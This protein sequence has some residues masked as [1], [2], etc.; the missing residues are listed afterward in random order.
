MNVFISNPLDTDGYKQLR[1]LTLPPGGR[2][3][4]EDSEVWDQPAAAGGLVLTP[5]C[6]RLWV[7]DLISLGLGV[8]ICKVEVVV[9]SQRI[10]ARLK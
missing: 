9:I 10:V 8:L 3:A 1:Q 4:R 6:R 7:S 5:S 2:E